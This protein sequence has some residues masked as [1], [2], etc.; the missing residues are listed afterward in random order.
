MEVSRLSDFPI[1]EFHPIPRGLMGPGAYELIGVEAKK[2]GFK[3]TLLMTSGLRGT[4]IIE[5]IVGK[6]K[7]QGVDVVVY[8]KVESN[9]KDYNVMDAYQMY[10]EE[11]CDSFISVGGG[12]SHDA[13]KAARIVVAHDGR[14]INE[15]EGFN[16]SENPVNPPHIAVSTTAGTGSETSWAYVITDTTGDEP[17]KYV[18]FDDASVTSLALLDPVLYYDC[19]ERFTAQ[20]GFDVLAHASEPY[21]S[22]LDMPPS[23]GNALHVISLTSQ[24]LRRAT[25]EPR[26]YEA[27]SGMM[28]AQYIAAQAFNS[29]GL[30]IIHS[31]SHAVSAFY[32]SH[33]GLNN[34]IALPRVWEFNLP[35]RYKRYADIAVAMGVERNGRT[36]V[37]MAEAALEAAIKLLKDVGIPE[38][39]AAVN[40]DTYPKNIMGEGVYKDAGTQIK[41]DD[42]DIDRITRHVLQDAC[43]P[44]NPR[45]CTFENVR[46]VVEHCIHGSL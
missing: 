1:K 21:V 5:D 4:D 31:I 43:T 41:G 34:A 30:G 2:L 42:A 33:H 10:A 24:H 45:E 14:N 29:G 20:C 12:S 36:D 15:F 9:P 26:N 18:G 25:Y 17:H 23:L 22:R 32:D 46:P 28:Y 27:R 38:N 40:K 6:V 3:K 16:K 19:P 35:A 37:Q 39:F 11:K 8:D 7:Y 13:C 44:G